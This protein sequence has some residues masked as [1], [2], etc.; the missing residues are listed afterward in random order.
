MGKYDHLPDEERRK[1]A[2]A[3]RRA[4][5]SI[6]T[7]AE[8]ADQ[9]PASGGGDLRDLPA[10]GPRPAAALRRR[11]S[12]ALRLRIDGYAYSEGYEI[13]SLSELVASALSFLNPGRDRVSRRFLKTL[14]QD[15]AER[16]DPS[17][18]SLSRTLLE[19][20]RVAEALLKGGSFLRR[21]TDRH[22]NLAG[23]L[24]RDLAAWEPEGL[25]LLAFFQHPPSGVLEAL[26]NLKAATGAGR[27]VDVLELQQLV[28]AVE[29][30]SLLAAAPAEAVR[31]TL[32]GIGALIKAQYRRIF[33]REEDMARIAL[34]ADRLVEEFLA[35]WA[36]LKWFAHELYPALLKM[37]RVYRREEE[38]PAILPHVLRFVDLDPREILSLERPPAPPPPPPPQ[39]VAEAQAP[40]PVDLG[41]EFRGILTILLQA[42]PGCR[43]ERM[44]EQDYSVL[45]WFQQ[46]IFSPPALRG[47]SYHRRQGFSD[48]LGAVSHLDPV[49]AVLV[50]HEIIAQ[51]LD[52]LSAEAVGRLVDPL[53]AGGA[54]ASQRLLDLRAQWSTLREVLLLR[55]LK[56]LA[57][58]ERQLS[59][60]P[61]EAASRYLGSPAGR[62]GVETVNQLRNHLVRGY[63]QVALQV[64]REELF[65]VPPLYTVNRELCELLAKLVPE[66]RQLG[67]LSP[68]PLHRLR[69]DDL[70]QIAPVP[71]LTQI[72]SWIEAVPA[73]ERLL[74]EPQAEF[75]RLFLEILYGTADLLDFLLNHD[76]SPLRGLGGRVLLA[77][78]ED[79][80]IR[81]EIRQDRAP[82]RVD[83]R[84]DCEQVDNLTG[85]HSKNEY[86]RLA[87]I[88]FR[89]E[90]LAGR[91]L[92]MLLADL[93]CF[94]A[95]NDSLGHDFGDTLLSLAGRAVLSCCREEDPATRFGGDEL[96]VVLRGNADAAA[97]LAARIQRTLEDFKAG[98]M[99][100]R[101]NELAQRQAGLDGNVA[102]IG[103]LSI[104]VAQGLGKDLPRPCPNEQSLFRRAERM[105]YLARGL[106]GGRTVVL[107]DAL[108]LPLTGEE[109]RDYLGEENAE[110]QAIQEPL[111]ADLRTFL[112]LRQEQ[113]PKLVF[114]GL[115]YEELLAE[116]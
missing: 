3:L 102:P 32:E 34:R 9:R 59:A 50:L 101:L 99:A 82:L 100:A 98:A 52:S 24:K 69:A 57:D 49:G 72:S 61:P 25:K 112:E 38:L 17:G 89:Q 97:R 13:C 28:R 67:A 85:L 29:R 54:P 93:D 35:C 60:L 88:L 19:L 14:V 64:D 87:P 16:G 42:F 115:D 73:S 4:A 90:R 26:D 10:T 39:P 30:S 56:E 44:A 47:P 18:Y 41:E 78:E 27:T 86:L 33:S 46:R 63:G 114:A 79:K 110:G 96:L 108:G 113:G 45:F 12:Y 5:Q 6:R 66:R 104:G 116:G 2:E 81:A 84:R 77:G 11:P 91:E 40:E 76:S 109:H 105:L 68:I 58:L 55:Y 51:M 53:A 94:R 22:Y 8:A 15:S 62:K 107:V 71:L 80:A 21:E 74:V 1:L 103:T 20:A 106:G 7:T 70:V 95:V 111:P 83:L 75:N 23:E 36:R 92:T 37:L 65:R 48:L 43:L 31:E